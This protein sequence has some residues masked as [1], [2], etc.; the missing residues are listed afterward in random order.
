[1]SHKK[2]VYASSSM[3]NLNLSKVLENGKRILNGEISFIQR[4]P[5]AYG[6]KYSNKK[7]QMHISELYEYKTKPKNFFVTKP[8]G[9]KQPIRNHKE[10]LDLLSVKKGLNPMIVNYGME[11]KDP[12][13]MLSSSPL[14]KSKA[15]EELNIKKIGGSYGNR[16]FFY[17]NNVLNDVARLDNNVY[18]LR[19]MCK[20]TTLSR[21][22]YDPI[23]RPNKS[24]I[25]D[26]SKNYLPL[27]QHK[28]G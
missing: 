7:P 11:Y 5:G 21:Y 1:M 8:L 20:P 28:Y 26:P 2:R 4:N 16:G 6:D 23:L 22:K 27:L 18:R 15:V 12:N 13:A 19:A 10:L 17:D 3:P 25:F 24:S 14:N 9:E